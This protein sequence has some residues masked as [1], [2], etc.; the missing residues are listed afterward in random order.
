MIASYESSM[1]PKNQNYTLR[2][3]KK[4][5]STIYKLVFEWENEIPIIPWQFITF[6]IPKVWAR[7]YSILEKSWKKLHFIIWKIELENGWRWGSKFLC[8]AKTWTELR[9]IWASGNFVVK[10]NEKNKLF[11]WTGTGF[12]PLYS[13]IQFALEN[14]YNWN[15]QLVFWVRTFADTF[16][17]QELEKLREKYKNFSFEIYLSREEKQGFKKWYITEYITKNTKDEFDETYIC[18]SPAMVDDARK[19]LLENRFDESGIFE[20]KY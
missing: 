15:L 6:L 17:L 14:N 11:L 10:E 20:E 19:K 1:R 8:E 3:T 13:M 12:V 5:N 16:Y 9:W 7:A 2:E 18:G 4:L